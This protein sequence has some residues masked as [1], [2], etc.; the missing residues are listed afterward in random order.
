MLQA[1]DCAWDRGSET[2]AAGELVLEVPEPLG[3][4]ND[5]ALMSA[6]GKGMK[7][8][9]AVR[10][11]AYVHVRRVCVHTYT[12]PCARVNAGSGPFLL[13][14]RVDNMPTVSTISRPRLPV[15]HSVYRLYMHSANK[16]CT[17]STNYAQGL[18]TTHIRAY[19]SIR[20]RVHMYT[21]ICAYMY[22]SEEAAIGAPVHPCDHNAT[23]D[24]DHHFQTIQPIDCVGTILLDALAAVAAG[25]TTLN[26]SPEPKGLVALLACVAKTGKVHINTQHQANECTDAW[27]LRL[28]MLL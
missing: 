12:C 17:V 18:Q 22:I 27:K 4:V 2:L 28:Y 3:L 23:R 9:R 5:S 15:V 6:K 11:H 25:V 10:I 26:S 13:S 1:G 20:I 21:R 19:T 8:R 16:L 14:L 7:K 24:S